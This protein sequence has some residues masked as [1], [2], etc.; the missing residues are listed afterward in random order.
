MMARWA[1]GHC[2]FIAWA[3]DREAMREVTGSHL[4]AHTPEAVTQSDFRTNWDCPY[5]ATAKTAYDV[6]GAVEEFKAHLHEHVADRI[7]ADAHVAD[8]F[9]WDGTVRID[10]PVD[11]DDADALRTH[12]HGHAEL[13]IAV[14]PDPERFVRLLDDRLD[15]WPR[16]TVVVST[17]AYRF[18][19]EAAVDVEDGSI[20]VVE[21]DPRLGP[22]ELGETVSRIID[23]NHDAGDVLSLEVSVFHEIVSA[24][25]VRTACG[26]VQ[27]LSA[28]LDDSGGSLQIY[29]DGDADPNVSTAMNFLDGEIDLTLTPEDGRFIR[30]A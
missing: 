12:F 18:D 30:R 9:D 16:R 11:S 13:V 5:C 15:A 8:R 27:M 22:D 10:A 6:D 4:L 14:T 3:D 26:F 19:E 1:C 24:F 21:L 17:E 25:D 29:A 28:R 20:E 2:G 23:A 7:V